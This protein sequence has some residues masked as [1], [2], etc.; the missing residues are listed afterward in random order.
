MSQTPII[1]E[2]DRKARESGS[3]K[4]RSLAKFRSNY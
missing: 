3:R 1:D 2:I 4:T